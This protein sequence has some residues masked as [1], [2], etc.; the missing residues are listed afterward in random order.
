MSPHIKPHQHT[1]RRSVSCHG[2]GLHTGRK[3]RMT[4]KPA[5]ENNGICF[6]RSDVACKPAI[7]ARMEKIIDTTLATTIGNGQEKISTTEHLMAAL[8]G[9]GIDN[10]EIDIDSHEVPIMDGSAGPFVHLLKRGGLK[11]QRALRK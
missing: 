7:P 10:A 9:A 6:Y 2:V 5:A 3:V 4:I 11:K 8:H 1:L